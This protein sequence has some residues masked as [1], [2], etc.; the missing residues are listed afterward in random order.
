MD[1]PHSGRSIGAMEPEF[2]A[3]HGPG[4][5]LWVA[6]VRRTGGLHNPSDTTTQQLVA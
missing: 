4:N 2:S 5:M 3:V 6:A 1:G